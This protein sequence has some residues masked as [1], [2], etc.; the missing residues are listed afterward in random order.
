[1]CFTGPQLSEV[2]LLETRREGCAAESKG[3]AQGRC[4]QI[5]AGAIVSAPVQH[6]AVSPPTDLPPLVD[7]FDLP[8]LARCDSLIVN[9]THHRWTPFGRG[10][11]RVLA[12]VQTEEA[13]R[14]MTAVFPRRDRTLASVP[15]HPFRFLSNTTRTASCVKLTSASTAPAPPPLRKS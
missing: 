11:C 2:L 3:L 1:M 4:A 13:S 6:A 8:T 10:D 7:V 12:A 5:E 14:R 15:N 9:P